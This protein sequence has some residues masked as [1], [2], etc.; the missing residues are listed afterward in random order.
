MSIWVKS[1]D[2]GLGEYN[3]FLPPVVKYK[4]KEDPDSPFPFLTSEVIHARIMGCDSFG[5]VDVLGQYPTKDEAVKVL[6]M[7]EN[8]IAGPSALVFQMPEAGFSGPEKFPC[9]TCGNMVPIETYL[10]N[11]GVCDL[12]KEGF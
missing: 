1:Q 11:D 5:N 6:D 10:S 2:G 3:K 8:H 4:E 9:N 7:I 12:C